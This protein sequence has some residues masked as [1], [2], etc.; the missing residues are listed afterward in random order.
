MTNETERKK[1][2]IELAREEIERLNEFNSAY[3]DSQLQERAEDANRD[4][5]NLRDWVLRDMYDGKLIEL[6]PQLRRE[7]PLNDVYKTILNR[8]SKALYEESEEL[9]AAIPENN[10]ETLSETDP[11]L[12]NAKGK[13][14][15]TLD[16]NREV[17]AVGRFRKTYEIGGSARTN[18]E[19]G[20]E[21]RG[22]AEAL[23]DEKFDKLSK[24]GHTVDRQTF[25]RLSII[26]VQTNG[27]SREDR[28]TY[29]LK[30]MALLEEKAKAKF[31]KYS[32]ST[33]NEAVRETLKLIATGDDPQGR[34]NAV[35]L[36]NSGLK[37]GG[38]KLYDV[39]E[40]RGYLG[41]RAGSKGRG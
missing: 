28:R 21:I 9:I 41:P 19:A 35:E 24:R 32:E 15:T 29:A 6:D 16:L 39:L 7:L 2:K 34:I 25:E 10:L 1:K 12:K 33:V 8:A 14:Q 30:G 11:V 23:A 37:Y 27:L 3:R 13:Y 31:D 26:A 5:E 20:F 40:D 4:I 36:V 38:D 18:E 17:V 22:A